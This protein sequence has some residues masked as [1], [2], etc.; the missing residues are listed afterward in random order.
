[1]GLKVGIVYSLTQVI[2]DLHGVPGGQNG[3]DNSGHRGV[4]DWFK[5]NTNFDRSLAAL[6][7]IVAEFSR[8]EYNNTVTAVDI[9]NEPIPQNNEEKDLLKSYIKHA[10]TQI[11]NASVATDQ[12]GGI[13]VMFSAAYQG[14]QTWDEFMPYPDYKR[15][16]LDYVGA[17]GYG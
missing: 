9:V 5:S 1:M 2:V 7:R 8:P 16:S 3:W 17:G 12:G 4:R 11:R 13:T 14:V 15:V 10:Y 6:D